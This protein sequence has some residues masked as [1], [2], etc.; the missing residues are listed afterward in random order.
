VGISIILQEEATSPNFVP[1]KMELSNV[2]VIASGELYKQGHQSKTWYRR[3]FVLSGIYLAY[4]DNKGL[5]KGKFDVTN[6]TLRQVSAEECK[7]PEALYAFMLEGPRKRLL[8]TASSNKNRNAWL[9]ILGKHIAA[10]KDSVRRFT[11]AAETVYGK[12][13]VDK[14]V[15]LVNSRS[16]KVLVAVTNYPRLLVIDPVALV[17]KEQFSWSPDKPATFTKVRSHDYLLPLTLIIALL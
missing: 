16:T 11:F 17:V 13:K 6:C 12:G 15:G 3:N 8:V 2:D 14:K 5:L 4:Y 9:T 1:K 7:R 10:L